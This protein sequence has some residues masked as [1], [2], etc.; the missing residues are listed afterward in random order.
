MSEV[1]FERVDDVP[2]LLHSDEARWVND[3]RPARGY[4]LG[5]LGVSQSI[6][7]WRVVHM[8]TGLMVN[9]G[10]G[11]RR[12]ADA[13]AYAV[14]LMAISGASVFFSRVT[15]KNSWPEEGME[16]VAKAILEVAQ[17]HFPGRNGIK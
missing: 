12:L 16:S 15:A 3:V 5:P 9:K 4:R 17:R 8:E 6:Y 1:R 10:D 14:A 2:T 13:K 11:Y 7:G